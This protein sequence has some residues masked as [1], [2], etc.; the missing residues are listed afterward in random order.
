MLLRWG[1]AGAFFAAFFG[2]LWARQRRLSILIALRVALIGL[3]SGL[4]GY[5][6]VIALGRFWFSGWLYSIVGHE[7]IAVG[8]TVLVGVL[9]LVPITLFY[10]VRKRRHRY[11]EEE[12]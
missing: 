12:R 6:V 11:I 5:V 9:A 10:L 2:F 8:V 4:L 1:I 3:V 7:Y